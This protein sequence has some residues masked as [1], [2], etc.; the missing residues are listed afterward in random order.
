[1]RSMSGIGPIGVIFNGVWQ[2]LQPPTITRYSPR[3]AG[4]SLAGLAD[5]AD[6]GATATSST[7]DTAHTDMVIFRIIENPLW[8]ERRPQNRP[9]VNFIP[10][11]LPGFPASVAAVFRG[12]A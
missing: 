12:P 3:L 7:T 11:P 5:L 1:M 10:T 8:P 4:S 9:G 6:A 2:S